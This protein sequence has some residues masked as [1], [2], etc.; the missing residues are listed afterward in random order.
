MA[1]SRDAYTR[2]Q[3]ETREKLER[4]Q[5]ERLERETR[6]RETR[7]RARRDE[8]DETSI[9]FPVVSLSF[10]K[11]YHTQRLGSKSVIFYLQ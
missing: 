10:H 5:K 4:D 7:E 9:F 11:K 3:R 2:D 6:Q 8:R 1:Y